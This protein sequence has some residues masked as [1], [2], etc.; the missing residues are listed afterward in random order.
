VTTAP[1]DFD[2]LADD[3]AVWR[4]EFD[5]LAERPQDQARLAAERLAAPRVKLVDES[6]RIVRVT[7]APLEVRS[8][9]PRILV[10]PRGRDGEPVAAAVYVGRSGWDLEYRLLRNDTADDLLGLLRDECEPSV[11]K[12]DRLIPPPGVLQTTFERLT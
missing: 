1:V 10:H 8:R 2:G 5:R 12:P 9:P 6:R 11:F 4:E 3:A 7:N